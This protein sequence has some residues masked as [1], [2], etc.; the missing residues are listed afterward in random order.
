MESFSEIKEEAKKQRTDGRTE[1]LNYKIILKEQ[2]NMEKRVFLFDDYGN[3]KQHTV[4]KFEASEA[5]KLIEEGKAVELQL[6]EFDDLEQQASRLFREY[7]SKEKKIKNSDDPRMT[8]EIKQ[9]DLDKAY[10][11][12]EE[13]TESLKQQW[14]DKRAEL[15]AEA[16][17]KAARA[18]VDVKD[19]DRQT[20][21][22]LA[23]RAQLNVMQASNAA[24]L[25]QTID[26]VAEDISY[27]TDSEK[28]ALQA[29]IAGVIKAAN[30]KAEQMNARASTRKI[31]TAVQDVNNMDLLAGKVA[32]QLPYTVGAEFDRLKLVKKGPSVRTQG[33]GR[34]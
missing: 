15:Q 30:R 23:N 21:E 32:D 13:Q 31:I 5:A 16:R 12:L 27:L 24:E 18:S 11:E 2:I 22:Q 28:V 33:I 7:K 14:R 20:A 4:T 6:T 17:R 1:L 19:A 29:E 8:D 25:N 26:R 3:F 9:Y 34:V 10:T